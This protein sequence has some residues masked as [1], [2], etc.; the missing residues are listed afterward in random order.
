MARRVLWIVLG[1]LCLTHPACGGKSPAEPTAPDPVD[2]RSEFRS[3]LQAL[4][5]QSADPLL[6]LHFNSIQQVIAAGDHGWS[7]DDQAIKELWT[8][9]TSGSLLHSPRLRES[10]L[11]RSRR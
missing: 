5:D 10:Y 4:A 1:T 3:T 7:T 9:F 2:Y 6:R 11:D 8:A